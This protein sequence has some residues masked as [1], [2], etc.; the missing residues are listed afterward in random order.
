MRKSHRP[1]W[2]RYGAALVVTGAA[3]A[4]KLLLVPLL[5]REQPVLLFILAAMVSAAF[6]GLGPGL[7]ATALGALCDEYFFMPPYSQF[8]LNSVS[9]EFR[10]GIFCVEG[11]FISVI[12]ARMKSAR[13]R[14]EASAQEAH[15]LQQRVIEISDAEQRRIGHDLHDGLGQHLTGIALLARRFQ[16]RLT[17][18]A[19]AEAAEAATLSTFAQSAVEWTHDLCRT[20]SPSVR[21]SSDLPEA[22]RDLAAKTENLFNIKCKFEQTGA[23]REVDL[24]RSVHLYRI[25]QEAISN[26]VRHGHARSVE[27]LV[28]YDKSGLTLQVEDDG[29]GIGTVENS[30]DGMGLRIMKY[31]AR[32]I[33]ASITL[34]QR[35][36]GGMLVSCHCPL[37]VH[38]QVKAANGNE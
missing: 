34:E 4:L 6:G 17:T 5:T 15:E 28:T 30:A 14:A 1:A 22:L 11:V 3:L 21:D 16:E 10:L 26:A 8:R 37:P 19:P 9:E 13:I 33:G 7:L 20:L 35:K 31:R 29:T 18:I 25:A 27:L 38:L 12:C 24:T 36:A 2:Q 32:L 23:L